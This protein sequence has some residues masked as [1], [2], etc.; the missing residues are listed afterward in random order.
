[1]DVAGVG[2]WIVLTGLVMVVIGSAIWLAGRTG[3]PLG[4]LPGDLNIQRER[5]SFHFPV[6]TCILASI[7]LTLLINLLLR[8]FHK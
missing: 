5:F 8:M 7:A 6:A 3:L 2:K 4:R 1:M